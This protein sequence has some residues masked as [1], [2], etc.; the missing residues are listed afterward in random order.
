LHRAYNWAT[1]QD[2]C[3][4]SS[5]PYEATE[6]TCQSSGC[7]VA[8]A[9][10]SIVGFYSVA[11]DAYAL[12]SSIAE[13]PV[14]VAV[15]AGSYDFQGYS[16]GIVT[17]SSCGTTLNHGVVAVGFGVDVGID[18]FVVR[19]SWGATWGENG[20]IRLGT[21][22]NVCGIINDDSNCFPA[23]AG[24]SPSPP[25]PP[26]PEPVPSPPPAPVPS[27]GHYG[28]PP[29]L[30]DEKMV[31]MGS[32]SAA[33]GVDCSHYTCPMDVPYGVSNS[34]ECFAFPPTVF[35]GIPCDMD[36]DC[37][38]GAIC[39]HFFHVCAYNTSTSVFV[40]V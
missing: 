33:C 14:A 19:N 12:K 9:L 11:A 16:S 5:Y 20:Y 38:S 40:S 37:V 2:L 7:D 18:Y 1:K 21:A 32:G 29:C 35:C 23:F 26:V 24:D 22:G 3:K 31:G 34:P 36:S 30:S 4:T 39:E 28:P 27:L 10:G 15:A 17:G 6:G 25:Q 8:I 13:G